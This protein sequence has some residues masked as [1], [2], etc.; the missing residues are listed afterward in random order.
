VIP[1]GSVP[2]LQTSTRPSN[3]ERSYFKLEYYILTIFVLN[4]NVAFVSRGELPRG[5]QSSVE[6]DDMVLKVYKPQE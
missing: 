4:D 2:A 5:R 3:H 1:N 6:Q